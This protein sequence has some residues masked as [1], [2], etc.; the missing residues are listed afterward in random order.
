MK[1]IKNKSKTNKKILFFVI[2][3]NLTFFILFYNYSLHPAYLSYL[4]SCN[5]D[6]FKEKGINFVR[7]GSASLQPNGTITVEITKSGNEQID[8]RTEKHE[9]IHFAQFKRLNHI[10]GCNTNTHKINQYISEV[11]AYTYQY[12]PDKLFDIIY[13]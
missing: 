13:R 6:K 3:V 1:K 12:L 10:A 8:T 2:T 4:D 7:V 9:F 5:P 11:E